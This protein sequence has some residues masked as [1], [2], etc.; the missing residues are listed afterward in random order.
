MPAKEKLLP[1]PFCGSDAVICGG[2]GDNF[3]VSCTS[4]VCFCSLGERYYPGDIPAHMFGD[5]ESAAYNWN[6]R[7]LGKGT[8]G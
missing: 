3:Y 7:T 8:V 5:K 4:K 1:C 6:R 2:E